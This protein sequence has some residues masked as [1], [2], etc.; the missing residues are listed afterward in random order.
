MKRWHPTR[1]GR[2]LGRIEFGEEN[3]VSTDADKTKENQ[4]RPLS[5]WHIFLICF[6]S[7]CGL[8]LLF[9]IYVCCWLQFSF[10]FH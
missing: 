1:S 4:R 7:F 9:L 5:G 2:V 10:D 8:V 3:P 6:T